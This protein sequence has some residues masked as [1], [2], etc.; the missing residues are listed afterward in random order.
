MEFIFSA[1]GE[2]EFIRL[3]HSLVAQGQDE[4]GAGF[5]YAFFPRKG[6]GEIQIFPRQERGAKNSFSGQVMHPDIQRGGRCGLDFVADPGKAHLLRGGMNGNG[7][8][9]L[10]PGINNLIDRSALVLASAVSIV[11]DIQQIQFTCR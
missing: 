7:L 10:A 9:T 6:L 3:N 1:L 8:G 4:N 11:A 5:G 2:N